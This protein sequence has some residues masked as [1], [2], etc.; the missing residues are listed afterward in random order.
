MQTR[1][2]YLLLTAL[3]SLSFS[4]TE[5]FSQ[6]QPIAFQGADIIPVTGNSITNG[7]LVI[8][9]GKI[10]AIGPSSSVDIPGNTEI[11]D[12]TGQV[13]MPCRQPLPHWR[14]RWR[15]QIRCAAP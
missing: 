5:L 15:R 3:F 1:L 7:T 8:E 13:I 12:V 6:D 10:V 14:G 4:A 2:S 11:V 9:D